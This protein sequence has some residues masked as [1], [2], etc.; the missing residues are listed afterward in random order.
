MGSLH[1]GSSR[2]WRETCWQDPLF[3]SCGTD[4]GVQREH[5]DRALKDE[6]IRGCF[7]RGHDLGRQK[8]AKEG[9]EEGQEHHKSRHLHGPAHHSVSQG[10]RREEGQAL[11]GPQCTVLDQDPG[12]SGGGEDRDV[13]SLI[14]PAGESV[15]ADNRLSGK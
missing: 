2:P 8:L 14:A 12:G 3:P 10:L 5:A 9:R 11:G 1:F 4:A 6:G 7:P 15:D 13:S